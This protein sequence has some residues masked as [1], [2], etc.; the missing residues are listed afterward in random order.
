VPDPCVTVWLEGD[1]ESEKSPADVELTTNV[2]IVEWLGL[3]PS[4]PVIVMV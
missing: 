1:G 3:P 4:L 2:T